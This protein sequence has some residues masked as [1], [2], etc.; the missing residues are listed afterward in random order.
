MVAL[1]PRMRRFAYSLTGNLDQAD[2]L[3]QETC[4]RA[5]SNLDKWQEGTR[6]D[7]WMFRI[8]QNLW[9]D[10]LR[11]MQV[12]GE[13]IDVDSVHELA[14]QDG[15]EITEHKLT[16]A[17]V[18]AA[19]GKLAAEQRVLV[20]LVCVEGLSYKEAADVIGAPIGT[21]MSRLARAR[22]ALAE[23]LGET[24]VDLSQVEVGGRR[25]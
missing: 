14:G 16:L 18:D 1:L 23:A 5:L 21:V 20:G 9:F 6:L 2:D 13:S 22:R 4:M 7:S 3:V 11:A 10:R 12:R 17:A 8:A 19:L 15:R 24:A 25:G